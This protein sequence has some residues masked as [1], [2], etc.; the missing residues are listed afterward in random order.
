MFCPKCG[1]EY[2]EGFLKCSDCGTNL[3]PELPPTK[4]DGEPEKPLIPLYSPIDE[5]ELSMLRGLLDTDGIRYFVLNDYF[6][7]MRVGPQ[8]DLVNKKT[9]MVA[10][11]DRDRAKEIISNFLP[12][13]TEEEGETR[14]SFSQKLRMV[15]EALLF[16]WFIT[17]RKRR[18]TKS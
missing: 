13:S 1:Y 6:G 16:T 14:Y 9:I 5:L 2:R 7:S 15:I 3:V 10:P 11:E 18:K 4:S 8:I 17:G 12:C